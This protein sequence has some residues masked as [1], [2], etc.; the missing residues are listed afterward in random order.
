MKDSRT[1]DCRILMITLPLLLMLI[2]TGF[3]YSGLDLWWVSHFYDFQR[4]IW[5]FMNHWLFSDIIHTGGQLFCKFLGLVWLISFSATF[6]KADYK[7]YRKPLLCFLAATVA[8]PALVAIGKSITHIYTP[9]D[10]QLFNGPQPYVK[11]LDAVSQG[12][13]VGHAFPAGHAS[14]GYAFSSL[15]FLFR[16][17][18]PSL[19]AYGISFGLTLGLIFGIG[20]QVRGAHFPSH[21]LF[22]MAICWLAALIVYVSFYPEE[23]RQ[24]SRC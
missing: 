4:Q 20:Q 23:W 7:S 13:L 15:Y 9:W 24:L 6:S 10:L 14:A 8:G 16:R 1:I 22:S 21:D 12:A 11:L 19:R 3:E 2:G 17:L 18:R 5:P